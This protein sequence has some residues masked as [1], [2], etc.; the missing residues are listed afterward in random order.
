MRREEDAPFD[1]E[2]W[3]SAE[4][5]ADRGH[6]FLWWLGQWPERNMA[7]VSH[8]FFLVTFFERGKP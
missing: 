1:P 8:G 3:E 2:R 6:Y 5:M 4:D 7:V